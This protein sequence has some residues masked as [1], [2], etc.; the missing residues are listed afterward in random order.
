MAKKKLLV[1]G[2]VWEC[3]SYK[4]DHANKRVKLFNGSDES[5]YSFKITPKLITPE[6]EAAAARKLAAIKEKGHFTD[7]GI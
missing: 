7:L 2:R 6:M 1:K 4:I 3:D 5:D